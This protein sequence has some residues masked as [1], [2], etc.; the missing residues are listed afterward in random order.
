MK[1]VEGIKAAVE[2]SWKRLF[3]KL[4]LNNCKSGDWEYK[5]NYEGAK[6]TARACGMSFKEKDE[7]QA[8]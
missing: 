4:A 1:N 5:Y 3:L 6:C 7:Q 2:I 8:C